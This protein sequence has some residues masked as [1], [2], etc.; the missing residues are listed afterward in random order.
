MRQNRIKIVVISLAL[1]AIFINCKNDKINN[2]K[3]KIIDF[4]NAISSN[5]FLSDDSGIIKSVTFI[6]LETNKECLISNISKCIEYNKNFFILSDDK[7]QIFSST[8][9]F[10]R[11]FG[12]KGNGPG[13]YLSLMDFAIDKVN[14]TV[15]IYDYIKNQIHKFTIDGKYISSFSVGYLASIDV[16][17]N[18]LLA[19]PFNISG[20]EPNSLLFLNG[21]GDT[22]KSSKNYLKFNRTGEL[23]L[24]PVSQPFYSYNSKSFFWQNNSDTIYSIDTKNLKVTPE[25]LLDNFNTFPIESFGNQAKYSEN[26]KKYSMVTDIIET[27]KFIFMNHLINNKKQRI[28]FIKGNENIL[29]LPYYSKNEPFKGNLL[30]SDFYWPSTTTDNSSVRLWSAI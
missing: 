12:N 2:S 3:E 13:E 16:V 21:Q 9:K 30:D 27:D 5:S 7:L 25:Y 24:I 22:L 15:Y 14:K 29:N 19:H 28:I 4:N 20:V 17:D 11:R 23:F 18:V 8:G 1:V 6:S 26:I 10:V